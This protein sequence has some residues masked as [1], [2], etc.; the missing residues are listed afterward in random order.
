MEKKKGKRTE[1]IT[2]K[3]MTA[4]IRGTEFLEK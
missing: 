1:K 4:K 2:F 3:D